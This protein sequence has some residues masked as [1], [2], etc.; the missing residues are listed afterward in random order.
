MEGPSVDVKGRLR[1]ALSVEKLEEAQ[2]ALAAAQEVNGHLNAE[3]E[4]LTLST[5]SLAEE[6][7]VFR[8]RVATLSRAL[9]EA[10]SV[11]SRAQAAEAPEGEPGA[12]RQAG[13][14]DD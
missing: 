7:D 3:I 2:I 11:A 4:R 6:R 10:Q 14:R 9:A 12:V 1:E 13:G 8:S 5:E